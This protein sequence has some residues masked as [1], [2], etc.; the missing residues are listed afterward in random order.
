M[1]LIETIARRVE[2][3]SRM[4]S[5]QTL[6]RDEYFW[7]EHLEGLEYF[8]LQTDHPRPAQLPSTLAQVAV[9]LD[10]DVLARL[11]DVSG[12]EDV[13]MF[14][15]VL[16]AFT[17][18]LHR[19]SG[20]RDI[21][22]GC[23]FVERDA[24]A[25]TSPKSP[26]HSFLLRADLAG[27]P[28]FA[29]LRTRVR[30]GVVA[31]FEHR[32]TSLP[33]VIEMFRGAQDPAQRGLF[34]IRFL[35][36]GGEIERVSPD[37]PEFF[38]MP[39]RE[40]ESMGELRVAMAL[41]VDGWFAACEFNTTLY[42]AGTARQM[43][44]HFSNALRAVSL[45]ASL[46]LSA[47][48]LLDETEVREQI[49]E[50]NDSDSVYPCHAT[51]TSLFEAQCRRSPEAVALLCGDEQLS[52]HQL[53][54]R[55]NALAHRLRNHGIGRGS[56]VAVCLP[57]SPELLIALLAVIRAGAAYVPLDP[58]Y[59]RLRLS[60]IIEDARPAA[61]LTTSALLERLPAT[62]ARTLLLDAPSDAQDPPYPLPAVARALPEDLAYVIFTSGSTGRPKG[63]QIQHRGLTNLLWAMRREPGLRA[64]D[65]LLSVTTVSFDIAALELFL[66]LIV[67]A[68]VVLA[69]AEEVVDGA[70]LL[71]LLRRH[72]V[73]VMQATPV[74]WQMLLAAGWNGDPELRM[75]CGGEA[76]SRHLA[77][78]LLMH[79]GELWN[80]YGPTETTIWSSALRVEAGTGPVLLGPPIANTQFYVLDAHRQRV[81]KGT[82][83]ELFIGGDGVALGYLNLPDLNRE[84]FV[85]NPFRA[86]EG[87]RM[88]RSGDR[89]RMRRSGGMEF[90][91]RN[92]QQIK[93]RGYRIELGD[94]EAAL[95][96]R[97]Q[98]AD[99]VAVVATDAAGESAIH[100]YIVLHVPGPAPDRGAIQDVQAEL[101]K[102][103]PTYM[104]PAAIVELPA[105][106]RTPNGKIDRAALPKPPPPEADA[107]QARAP[108]ST[109]EQA[110]A[111]IWNE[112]L[113]AT[114]LEADSN[115]FEVGGHS[116]LAVRL[117]ARI[118]A[119]YGHVLSLA[120]L[121]RHPTLG[122][123]AQLLHRMDASGST[124]AF[125]FRQVLQLQTQGSRTPLIALN[126][127][128]IY[129][130]LSRHLGADQPFISL[131]L[132]D[133]EQPQA[134]LPRSLEAIAAGYVRLIGRVQPRGPCALL[135]WCVA[136]T[137]AFEVAR[138]LR[139]SGRQVSQLVLFDTLVPGYLNRL[140]WFK[141][142][143]ADYSFRWKLIAADWARARSGP[144]PLATFLGNREIVKKWRA[145]MR[146][147]NAQAGVAAASK[148][149]LTAEQYDQWLLHYLEEAAA[150]YEPKL[151][152]GSL[153]LFRS[154]SEP[155]G[156]FL[157]LEMGWGTFAKGGVEVQI[158]DGDHFSIFQAPRV[159]EM[160]R[161]LE[162]VLDAGRPQAAST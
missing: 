111:K 18:L 130:G 24:S 8:E 112:M 133:P 37:G 147:L 138:Q 92:D 25:L 162:A 135:G 48:P 10:R 41:G 119:A 74:T 145:W 134:E 49:V 52:F 53:E 93:L 116:L 3:T 141:S 126:N 64:E 31:A 125:D 102:L 159:S 20:E 153:T 89:V 13:S 60:Q 83:G 82:P 21:G 65:T 63:V 11:Q 157:D 154:S 105:L 76:L 77:D 94:I 4:W 109:Q 35:F 39:V 131:Q 34:S 54:H 79:G 160:A 132:F 71:R 50:D 123:Q 161:R 56:L 43:L 51:V 100:A 150:R 59:P 62:D 158:L 151:Y 87:A 32:S 118:E 69:R 81:S 57:R 66:P 2:Q 127:T 107:I 5:D 15:S 113:E 44:R 38:T 75:W 137:L 120:L 27:N 86:I 115:F 140:P 96:A 144:R 40:P 103:L 104:C 29:A 155:M 80:L 99:A 14:T 84:R 67:G 90:L 88:Y 122:A 70:A 143:L 33:R 149:P 124:R 129:Y 6:Q 1:G 148:A 36:Q 121:F 46:P 55:M 114:D 110:L 146:P 23:V 42:E 68:K 61:L 26:A 97:P 108:L 19:Y 12:L 85:P 101:R 78:Q 152:P 58:A 72:R 106:P 117:L 73:T 139:A 136:G 7:M 91:G 17:L 22:I 47:V 128:G 142:L 45:D 28:R 98:V 95:R 156:R 30:D 16:A 9:P